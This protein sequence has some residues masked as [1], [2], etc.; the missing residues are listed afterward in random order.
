MQKVTSE[1][2]IQSLTSK[3]ILEKNSFNVILTD[4][5]LE[6]VDK[7]FKGKNDNKIQNSIF[8]SNY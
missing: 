5:G 1:K 6:L 8:Q 2:V 4:F 7:L 3:K